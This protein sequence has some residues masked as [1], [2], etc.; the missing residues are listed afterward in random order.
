MISNEPLFVFLFQVLEVKI[1]KDQNTQRA[2]GMS[3]KS[4][5]SDDK[6]FMKAIKIFHVFLVAFLRFH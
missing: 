3:K 4:A 6:I 2:R 5:S 1:P